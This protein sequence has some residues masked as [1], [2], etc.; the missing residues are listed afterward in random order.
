MNAIVENLLE[1]Y[2]PEGKAVTDTELSSHWQHFAQTL[3][4]ERVGDDVKFSGVGFGVGKWS[5]LLHRLMDN[6]TIQALRN[7]SIGVQDFKLVID[8]M[9]LDYTL[10]VYRQVC[11]ANLL[12]SVIMEREIPRRDILL[13]GEG[14]GVLACLLKTL[15]PFA[16][17][18]LVDMGPMLAIQAYHCRKA[19]PEAIHVV[20]QPAEQVY[21]DFLYLTPDELRNLEG[22][23]IDLAA[24][25]VAFQEMPLQV[26]HRYMDFL[27]GHVADRHLVY[28]NS[29]VEK[30]L[31]GGEVIRFADYSW[32]PGD[33]AILDELCPWHQWFW[34]YNRLRIP[35]KR[36]YDGLIKHWL[37]QLE[38]SQQ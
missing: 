20:S 14:F 30:Q 22:I 37:G 11:T 12:H 3:R 29:R 21:H 38:L 28:I 7:H 17:I 10:D 23:E 25:V 35:V 26:I 4:A 19:F 9:G 31:M 36:K 27:R 13:I 32:Q 15:W 1:K 18:H 8:R 34:S 5:N 24:S 6:R 33:K 2:Y 16:R